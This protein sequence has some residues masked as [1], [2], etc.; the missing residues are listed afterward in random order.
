M[1][2]HSPESILDIKDTGIELFQN[3]N[4]FS[5]LENLEINETF[6]QELRKICWMVGTHFPESL[7]QEGIILLA[8][9]P[10]LGFIQWHIN[11]KSITSLKNRLGNAFNGSRMVIRLYDVTGIEFDGFN[12]RK[13]FDID[14][15]KLSGC[16]YLNIDHSESNLISEIGFRLTDNRF[17]SCARSNTM[18]FDRPRRSSRLNFSGLYVSHGFNRIFP[19]ENAV[20]GSVFD[21]MNQSLENAGGGQLSVAV[22]L[23][24]SAI[25]G[26]DD[27]GPI[28]EFLGPVLAKCE[29]MRAVPYLF[30]SETSQFCNLETENITLIDKAVAFSEKILKS[31][32]KVHRNNPFDCVQC[33]DWYSAPAAIKASKEFNLPLNCVLHSLEIERCGNEMTHLSKQIEKWESSLISVADNI[34]VSKEQ[35][36][37][38]VIQ[39]YCKNAEKVVVVADTFVDNKDP[40]PEHEQTRRNFGIA[41]NEPVFLFAGEMSHSSGVDLIVEALPNVCSE[42]SYGQFV[43]AGEGYLKNQLEHRV[44]SLGMAHRCRFPGDIDSETFDKLLAVCDAVMI[45]SRVHE[46][47]GLAARSLKTGIPVLATHQAAIQEIS[48]GVN[49]ILVYDNPGSVCWGIK[50]MLSRP[51]RIIP[52]SSMGN[53]EDWQS[54]E[55]IAALYITYWAYAVAQRKGVRCG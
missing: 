22:F 7:N 43:F 9:N 38:L 36:R 20:Y 12:A 11:D 41:E 44:W 52:R 18:Y 55:C 3:D 5:K 10:H 17:S 25:C 37:Q 53:P 27:P 35:T 33:H 54:I 48:H 46:N 47:G 21:R 39:K 1:A 28:Q 40:G 45:P 29:T 42:Y 32:R 34:L 49:G 16:Y 13:Q 14:I 23:N 8:V 51:I 30:K 19:V 31:F 15:G 26:S 24:E 4:K 6:Q 50:E 2:D